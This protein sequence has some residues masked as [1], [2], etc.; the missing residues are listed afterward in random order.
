MVDIV[1]ATYN[2]EKYLREQLDSIINQT[3]KN[4][5]IY[6]RDDGSKDNTV[7]I[8]KEYVEEY[9]EKIV[10]ITDNVKCGS[11][12]SNFMQAMKYTSSE[13]IMFSDQDDIW[14]PEKIR[15]SLIRM[16]KIENRYGP[17]IPIL[18]FG[19]Y[20]P[21]DEHLNYIKGKEKKRQEAKYKLNF[22]N[23]LVQNYVNGCLMIINRKL[24]ELMGEYNDGI[25]MHDWWAALIAAGAGKINHIDEVMMLYRQHT[26]NVVGS[27]DV[28]SFKYRIGKLKD[29]KTK[30]A[31]SYYF[32][33]AELLYCR[34]KSNLSEKN[35]KLLKQFI[36]L[37][38]KK[39]RD[40]IIGLIKG[41]YL[42][43][44]FVRIM[45]QF[46]YI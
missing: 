29:P 36:E 31:S 40:K 21:V 20:R 17:D 6:I 34:C 28:K 10:Y 1:I 3:Y 45:G 5:K 19:S 35:R 22:S 12:K 39:K 9:P 2:G 42:K 16:K 46:W 8:I 25:L 11:A 41:N 27:V 44:D 43:S 33:Q 38:H 18:V 26:D 7:N 13:Y 32:R 30:D 15:H 37:Y 23:L 4:I 14:L 24:A